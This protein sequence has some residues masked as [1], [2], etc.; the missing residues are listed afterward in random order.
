[1]IRK[2]LP[3]ANILCCAICMLLVL[4]DKIW[5]KLYLFNGRPVKLFALIVCLIT[6]ANSILLISR[7]RKSR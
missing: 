6:A 4:I 3:Q 1:M 2:Y 5:P 7:N